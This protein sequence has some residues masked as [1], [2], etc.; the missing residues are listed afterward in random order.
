MSELQIYTRDVYSIMFLFFKPARL[1]HNE[2]KEI[3]PAFNT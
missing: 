3:V 1:G 2:S